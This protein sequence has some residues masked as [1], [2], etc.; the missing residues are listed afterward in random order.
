MLNINVT[1]AKVNKDKSIVLTI[2]DPFEGTDETQRYAAIRGGISW[3]TVTSPAYYCIVAMT[4]SGTHD[5]ERRLV[6]DYDLLAE[7]ESDS[8][9]LS[10]FYRKLSDAAEQYSCNDFYVDMPENRYEC[11]YVADFEKFQRGRGSKMYALEAY[12]VDNFMLGISRIRQSVDEGKL[13]IPEQS[14]LYEQLQSITKDDLQDKPEEKFYG[15]NALRHVIGSYYREQPRLY[16]P[17]IKP[18]PPVNW[19]A[20]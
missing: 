8:L 7:Y 6:G 12:D 18:R 4:D 5:D 9:G 15:V 13:S 16:K 11:G 14:V 19:R 3:P 1:A 2:A 10:N 17:R 20:I